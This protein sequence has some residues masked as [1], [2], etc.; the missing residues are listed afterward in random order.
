M[1]LDDAPE[2]DNVTDSRGM[3]GKLA[4]GGGGGLLLLILGLVFGVDLGGVRPAASTSGPPDKETLVFTKKVLGTTEEVW[5]AE[6][7]KMGKKY[8]E[9]KLDLFTERVKTG[10]GTAPSA[11]GPFYC[12]PDETVYIDPTFFNELEQKLGGSKADFSKAYVIAHEV[13]HHVQKLLGFSARAHDNDASVRL[14][15]QADYL[16]GVWA[17][18]GQEKFKF[19]EPGDVEAAIK[20]ANAIGDDR[21]QKRSGSFVHPEQFTHGTSRQRVYFFKRGLKTGDASMA[22]LQ[23]FFEEPM[24]RNGELRDF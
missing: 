9:P 7:K 21:L 15:L 3:G 18:H 20:S 14:E 16:A 10:C 11:V 6:F 4:I 22:T 5:T 17:H 1:R 23:K 8:R 2:S 12:P 24:G 13:G 19:I